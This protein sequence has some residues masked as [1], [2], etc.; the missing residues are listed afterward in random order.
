MSLYLVHGSIISYIS[1]WYYGPLSWEGK[2]VLDSSNSLPIWTIPI[3]VILSLLVATFVTI[4]IEEP[5]RNYLK[6]KYLTQNTRQKSN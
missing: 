5:A 6:K 3:S 2:K 4:Y 1:F